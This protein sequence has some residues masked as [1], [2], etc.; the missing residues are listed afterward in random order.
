M[1]DKLLN[2]IHELVTS[3][4]VAHDRVIAV[5]DVLDQVNMDRL[6]DKLFEAVRGLPTLAKE[7]QA[8]HSEDV[9]RQLKES[10]QLAGNLLKATLAGLISPRATIIPQPS[11]TEAGQETRVEH[12]NGDVVRDLIKTQVG[13]EVLTDGDTLWVNVGGVCVLRVSNMTFV[14]FNDKTVDEFGL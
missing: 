3:V 4:V 5:A 12:M 2:S 13:V 11:E 1:T 8:A 6:S 14:E 10:E 7:V 9:G